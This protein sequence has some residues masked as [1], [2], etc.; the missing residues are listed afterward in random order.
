MDPFPKGS[1]NDFDISSLLGTRCRMQRHSDSKFFAGWISYAG[2]GQLVVETM[3]ATSIHI[4]DTFFLETPLGRLHVTLSCAVGGVQGRAI[5]L[6]V[7][8]APEFTATGQAPRFSGENIVLAVRCDDFEGE[9]AV[10]DVSTT[11]IG[12][13]IAKKLEKDS[14][15]ALLACVGQVSIESQGTVRYCKPVENSDNIF[16]VGVHLEFDDRLSKARWQ[17]MIQRAS[18]G[19]VAA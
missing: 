3:Q 7:L 2:H 5:R 13:T 6:L 9:V 12:F 14:W 8:G 19:S 17:Q 4:G 16:R 10:V 18:T 15:V 1:L 11:G